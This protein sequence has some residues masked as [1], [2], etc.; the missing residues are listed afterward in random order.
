[1]WTVILVL[2][3]RRN[4]PR[5]TFCPQMMHRCYG[6]IISMFAP[7]FVCWFVF[8]MSMKRGKRE[9]SAPFVKLRSSFSFRAPADWNEH[10]S[11]QR[12][13]RTDW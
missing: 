13:V 9:I 7:W 11:S 8:F 6:Q 12:L 3:S 5:G 4:K 10:S 2:E 1:M